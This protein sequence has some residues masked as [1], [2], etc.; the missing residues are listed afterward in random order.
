MPQRR[1]P[2]STKVLDA[3]TQLR[4]RRGAYLVSVGRQRRVRLDVHHTH[5]TA[6]AEHRETALGGDTRDG[7]DE[8]GVGSDV[9]DQLRPAG[10]HHLTNDAVSGWEPVRDVKIASGSVTA[11]P[12]VDEQVHARQVEPCFNQVIHET[13]AGTI[14][15][16][17]PRAPLEERTVG[18]AH[19]HPHPLARHQRPGDFGAGRSA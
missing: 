5:H 12:F 1:L 16:Q 9:L 14:D 8:L 18:N 13:V 11:H 4:S 7:G 2:Q 3:L 19:T 15:R 10:R 17:R 6:S